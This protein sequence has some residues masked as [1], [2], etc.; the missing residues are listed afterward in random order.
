MKNVQHFIL[1]KFNQGLYTEPLRDKTGQKIQRD[2]WMKQRLAL[3]EKYCLPSIINQV[4]QEFTWLLLLDPQ[5]PKKY[6]RRLARYKNAYH[7]IRLCLGGWFDSHLK[8]MIK[9]GTKFLITTRIDNDD[10]LHQKAIRYI[11]NSFRQQE[12]QL[13]GFPLGYHLEGDRLYLNKSGSYSFLSLIEKV[14]RVDG[15]L[16]I[17]TV[18]CP[19]HLRFYKTSKIRFLKP[20]TP[21]WLQ[22]IHGR[23]LVNQAKGSPVPLDELNRRVFG[24]TGKERHG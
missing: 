5:T 11:Q 6:L 17:K 1:T 8:R 18:R 2:Q 15:R 24:I 14:R 9:Q 13:V 7:N 10:A 21:M 4:N 20:D 23:N 16:Q 3:F 19:H 12:L 22:I